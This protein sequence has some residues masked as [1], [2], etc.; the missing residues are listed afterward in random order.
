MPIILIGT[1]ADLRNDL[2][3]QEHLQQRG[4]SMVS[5]K[6]AENLA[7]EIGAVAYRECSALTQSGMTQ[8]FEVVIRAGL[9]SKYQPKKKSSSVGCLC[10]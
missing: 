6:D 3:I 4:Q 9:K 10:S 2:N 1:K 7:K 8:T 5:T